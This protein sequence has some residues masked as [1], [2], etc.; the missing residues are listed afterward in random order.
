MMLSRLCRDRAECQSRL[1]V[2]TYPWLLSIPSR[3]FGFLIVAAKIE[4]M[5]P[6]IAEREKRSSM[7]TV[8][9]LVQTMM[10]PP[11]LMVLDNPITEAFLPFGDAEAHRA[12]D[13]HGDQLEKNHNKGVFWSHLSREIEGIFVS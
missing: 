12:L 7:P 5:I 2:V 8:T 9:K 13:R 6:K 3:G 4:L 10:F 1:N 11:S